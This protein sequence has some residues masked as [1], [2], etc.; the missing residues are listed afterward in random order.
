M[1]KKTT[2]TALYGKQS[3]TRSERVYRTKSRTGPKERRRTPKKRF[4]M[5]SARRPARCCTSPAAQKI[6]HFVKVKGSLRKSVSPC[7]PRSLIHHAGPADRRARRQKLHNQGEKGE[8]GG[9]EGRNIRSKRAH[10]LYIEAQYVAISQY[11]EGFRE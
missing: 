2:A 9:K 1:R 7:T 5:A 8:G 6:L 11:R 10:G 3:K 4:S